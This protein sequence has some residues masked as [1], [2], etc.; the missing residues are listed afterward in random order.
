MTTIL[1]ILEAVMNSLWQAAIVA[2]LVW[3]ALRFLP[4]FNVDL[5]AA[6]RYAIWWA[7]LAV[8]LILPVAPAILRAMRT[9]PPTVTPNAAVSSRA[10][11]LPETPTEPVIITVTPERTARWPLAIVAIWAAILLFRLG[12]IT[13]S[14]FYLR[15]VKMRAEAS[16]IP[17]PTSSR[18]ADPLISRDIA[19]PMAVGFARPAVILPESLLDELSEPELEHVL[20]HEMAH[21]AGYDD[22]SNLAMRLL[23]AA[24][25]LHPVAVWILR[26]IERE[27]EMVCDDWVVARTSDARPYA[28]TLARLFEL[29]WSK[30]SEALAPGLF[31]RGTS[32]G[33]RIEMLLRRGRTFSPRLAGGGVATSALLL[34]IL[35]TAVSF[36]PHWVAFARAKLAFE[37]ASIKP[38]EPDSNRV[39][40]GIRPGNRFGTTNASLKTLIGFAFDL[41]D[42]QISG[43]PNWITSARFNIDAKPDPAIV[44]AP[45]PN[46]TAQMREMVQSLLADRFKLAFHHETRE[47]PVYELVVDKG[48]PKLKETMV[49]DPKQGF[50]LRMGMAEINATATSVA[51]LANQLSQRLGRSVIDKTGLT[52]KYDFVLKWTPDA[53]PVGGPP[54]GDDR[55]PAP[56]PNGP[57][58]F[59]ALQQD[60]GLKLQSAKGPVEV[61]IIDH[62]EKPDAN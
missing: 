2:A 36:A 35:M 17:L 27:R 18:R 55:E 46:G 43:G 6:T 10:A 59:G 9:R 19:S 49:T 47:E 34:A 25:A 44:I 1:A 14:Y 15:G 13:R 41:R 31:G 40:L 4:R 42:H 23:G 51:M 53:L 52:G 56:D 16:P 12:Q 20:L 22:W 33:N 24:F 60:L 62:A 57:S 7:A 48:G 32:V 39:S 38:G 61:L 8:V 30:R 21:L 3:L 54:R 45:P 28:A 50:G 26:C 58:I 29:R 5:N 11:Q 37:V